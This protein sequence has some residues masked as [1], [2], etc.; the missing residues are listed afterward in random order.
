[1][2]HSSTD[3]VQTEDEILWAK[4]IEARDEKIRARLIEKYSPMVSFVVA[5]LNIPTTTTLDQDDLVS[6]GLIGLINALD[7]FEPSRGVKFEAYATKRIRGAVIDQLRTLNWM[8]RSTMARSRALERTLADLEQRLGRPATE[9]EIAAECGVSIERYRQMLIDANAAILSL[10][11]P[12]MSSRSDDDTSTLGELLE[13][14]SSADPHDEAIQREMQAVLAAALEKLPARERLLLQLYYMEEL[15]M[16]EI[17]MVIDVSESR[18]CQLHTQAILR[19]RSYL[20]HFMEQP[21]TR[22]SLPKKSVRRAV[23]KQSA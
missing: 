23:M 14:H 18:V 19:M 5:R 8:S 2:E 17:S 15:T 7:R 6:Y 1:M 12:L 3:V 4:F 9:D 16:K 21:T 10:D 13:D 20:S 22:A 11:A